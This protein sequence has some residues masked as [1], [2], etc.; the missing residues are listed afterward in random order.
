ME[1]GIKLWMKRLSV[2]ARYVGRSIRLLTINRDI[3]GFLIFLCIA[4]AF[5]FAQTFKDRT[6]ASIDYE[7]KMVNVPRNIIFTSE[8]PKNISVTL[9]GRGFSILQ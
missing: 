1:S 4:I 6:T 2:F 3:F 9:S 7:L 5:W 8:V